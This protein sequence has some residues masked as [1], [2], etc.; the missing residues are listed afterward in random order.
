MIIL[1]KNTLVCLTIFLILNSCSSVKDLDFLDLYTV[2]DK[3]IIEGNRLDISASQKEMKVD[4]EASKL[5][6]NLEGPLKNS[7]WNKKGKNNYNVPENM[8]IN[9]NIEF[10]WKKDV[11]DG[12]G[13]YNKIYTQP[14]GN[15]DFLYV[16]DAEGKL[17]SLNIINGDIIWE[18]YIFPS[19]ES[20]NTNIDGGLVL[21]G[22]NLV[23]SSSYG[24]I[25]KLN[26]K[27]GN[28][29]WKKN[30]N[31]PVQGGP[32]VFNNFIYQMTVANEL[33]V[34]DINTGKE[35]WR[36]D[37]SIVSAISNGAASPVVNSNSVIFPSNTGELISLDTTTGSLIWSTS[38]V[39]EGSIS[40][41]LEL[42]DIDS[43]PVMH[44]DLIY[45]SSLSGKFAVIDAI[46][47][48]LIWEV[49]I[50]TSNNPIINGDAVFILSNDGRLINLFS[51]NGNIRW[52]SDFS[53]EIKVNA[54]DA[55][56]C[57]GPLLAQ[58]DIWL[59][60][61]DGKVFKVNSNNGKYYNVFTLDSPSYISPIVINGTMIFYTEDAEIIAYR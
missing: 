39:I 29:E 8:F 32:S 27:D 18:K 36:Y 30:I 1:F 22:N 41:S 33:F 24:E 7:E 17:V 61:Q 44:K 4:L 58:D 28:I 9:K 23:A 11:G 2:D 60:C 5:P 51:N 38:L 35:I 52:I 43:G 37:A 25:I 59:V 26:I 31:A 49:P 50:K 6:I 47:G 20:I 14:V 10:L 56:L 45:S 48:G 53:K 46:S 19:E 13:T 34:I 40:G 57:S 12:E 55:P 16:L 15:E 21:S 3:K 42:T 54:K